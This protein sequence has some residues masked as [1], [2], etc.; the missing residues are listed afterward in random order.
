MIRL[1]T[2]DAHDRLDTPKVR[3]SKKSGLLEA[4]GEND[5]RSRGELWR[6]AILSAT[7]H[8]EQIANEISKQNR[9][10]DLVHVPDLVA[11][12]LSIRAINQQN[13]DHPSE[14]FFLLK[15]RE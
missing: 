1:E 15:E 4:D 10:G 5:N 7:N 9:L 11:G 6:E 3:L 12:L 8:I 14:I 13:A 2:K